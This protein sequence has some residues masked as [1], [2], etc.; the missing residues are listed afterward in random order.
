MYYFI[1]IT[2]K[3]QFNIFSIIKEKERNKFSPIPN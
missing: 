3:C 1:V 2:S